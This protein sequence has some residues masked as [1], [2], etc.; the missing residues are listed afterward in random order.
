M[1]I[2]SNSLIKLKHKPEAMIW[3]HQSDVYQSS[4]VAERTFYRKPKI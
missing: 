3:I 4:F 1:N 2:Y